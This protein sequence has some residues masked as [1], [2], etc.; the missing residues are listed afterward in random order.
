MG[1]GL[2]IGDCYWNPRWKLAANLVVVPILLKY[3]EYFIRQVA[4]I[5]IFLG[6]WVTMFW[7]VELPIVFSIVSHSVGNNWSFDS[8]KVEGTSYC[9]Y[10]AVCPDDSTAQPMPYGVFGSYP[11]LGV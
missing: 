2:L 4:P 1:R 5:N 10:F 6:R 3:H 7:I 11:K 8:I 9:G